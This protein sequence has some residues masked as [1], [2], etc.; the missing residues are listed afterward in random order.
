MT[1]FEQPP[2]GNKESEMGTK[3]D[4]FSFGS[5]MTEVLF[6]IKDPVFMNSFV[7]ELLDDYE[8]VDW[9]ADANPMGADGLKDILEYLEHRMTEKDEKLAKMDLDDG[10]TLAEF[11]CKCLA[12]QPEDRPTMKQVAET[13]NGLI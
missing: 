4:V 10:T 2:V 12:E 11:I 5:M 8:N 13:L 9:D 7:K 3:G 1:M 6:G